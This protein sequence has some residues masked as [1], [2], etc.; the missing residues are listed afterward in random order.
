M[1]TTL[2]FYNMIADQITG[3]WK[4][5]CYRP[6]AKGDEEVKLTVCDQY[7]YAMVYGPFIITRFFKLS[8]SLPGDVTSDVQW[9][10]LDICT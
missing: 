1:P 8:I 7:L 5:L 2:F 6:N 10:C 3:Q 9:I 4:H